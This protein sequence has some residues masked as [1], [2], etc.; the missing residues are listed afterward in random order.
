MTPVCAPANS[1]AGKRGIRVNRHIAPT[2]LGLVQIGKF[3]IQLQR[4][5]TSFLSQTV[6]QCRCCCALG[7]YA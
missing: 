3:D 5:R 1:P 4:T 2:P 6:S 7:E